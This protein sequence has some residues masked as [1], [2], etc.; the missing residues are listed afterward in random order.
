MKT[1]KNSV[2]T[3]LGILA[4]LMLA[5]L[6][7]WIA[8]QMLGLGITGMSNGTSWGLYICLFL[9]FVGLSAGGL[10]VASAGSVFH[11]RDYEKIALPAI[12]TSLSC[13]LVAG[14]LVLVDLGGIVRIWRILTGPN[15][16]SPLVWDMCV[17]TLYIIMNIVELV[18]LVSRKEGAARKQWIASCIALPVAILVHSVTAW[19]LGLQIGRDWYSSIM[20]PLF[21][22]SAMDSGLGLLIL[23]LFGLRKGD[24]FKIPNRLFSQ[25]ALLLATVV[26]LDL[27]FVGCEL[28]TSAYPQEEHVLQTLGEMLAG[29]T[30]P[31]FWMEIIL[32][33]VAFVMLASKERRQNMRVVGWASAFVIA[34][35]FCK[36]IWLLFSSFIHPNIAYGP[37]ITSGSL[38]ARRATGDQIWATISNYAPTLPEIMIA[39]A[40]ISFGVAV[41]I[42]LMH[43]L[44]PQYRE[45]HAVEMKELEDELAKEASTPA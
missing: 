43:K 39:L 3:T 24:H 36:R 30:A 26:A 45:V 7:C 9:L 41:F 17:I 8:Q 32:L 20:A 2:K 33:V 12:A 14:A 21:V 34:S 37:G 28:L 6:G 44:L 16:M 1:M 23:A 11:V 42:V 4:V 38:T 15:F 18:F 25:L 29:A 27:Y 22:V 13:I 5:G 35:V 10:I 40:V 31:A 19:I